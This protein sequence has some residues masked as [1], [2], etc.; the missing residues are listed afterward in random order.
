MNRATACDTLGRSGC[1]ILT[2]QTVN[3]DQ[4]YYGITEAD[5]DSG[6]KPRKLFSSAVN[7]KCVKNKSAY[8][9]DKNKLMKW[10]IEHSENEQGKLVM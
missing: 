2:L 10:F 4:E 1:S 7:L 5:V 8:G 9:N 3:C 6:E